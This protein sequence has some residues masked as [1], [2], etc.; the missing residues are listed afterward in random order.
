MSTVTQAGVGTAH[1]ADRD[2]PASDSDSDGADESFTIH[3]VAIGAG[4][5]TVGRSGITKQ[6][7]ADE[8]E[9]AADTLEGKPLVR[10]HENTTDG[11]IGTVVRAFYRAGVGVLYQAEIAPHYEDI[12]QDIEAGI[13][14]V[15]ARAYHASTETLEADDETGALVV[16][17]IV[18]DNLAVVSQGAAPS[19]TVEPG[20]ATALAAG[21]SGNTVAVMSQGSERLSAAE[22][23]ATFEELDAH[24]YDT[25]DYVRGDSSGGT[26][27]GRVEGMKAE[28]CYSD[29]IDG[30]QEICAGDDEPVYL[31][32][33]VDDVTGESQDT[34]V[35]HLESSIEGWSGPSGEE[36]A[37][38]ADD[39]D[40]VYEEFQSV[41]NMSASELERWADHPCATE[42]SVDTDA[43]IDRNMR[44]LDTNKDDWDS[45][46]I[47]DAQ[48]TIS[49][50]NRMSSDDNRPE[51]P[52]DGPH[53]CPSKWAISLLNWAHNPFDSMPEVPDEMAESESAEENAMHGDASQSGGRS[54]TSDM[55]R[56]DTGDVPEWSEGDLV[57]WQVE[58]DLFGT[59]VHVD[60]ETHVAMVEI[61]GMSDSNDNVGG[62]M[63]STGFTITA[64]FSDI[65]PMNAPTAQSDMS[66]HDNE[67]DEM[68][69]DSTPDRSDSTSG[70]SDPCD[71]QSDS[72]PDQ[73]DSGDGRSDQDDAVLQSASMHTPEWSGLDDSREW[74]RPS[75]SDFDTDDLS[76]IDDH[77]F[78]SRTGFPPDAYGDLALP[79]VWP[80]GDLSA[81]ALDSVHRMATQT[82]GVPDDTTESIKTRAA[83]LAEEHFDMSLGADTDDEEASATPVA[84]L[85]SDSNG[86]TPQSTQSEHNPNSTMTHIETYDV[87]DADF[88]EE[89]YV[90]VD[91]DELDT[92]VEQ[93]S[94][95]DELGDRIDSVDE[96]LD[97][98]A[99]H[100]ELMSEVDDDRL[101]ELRAYDDAVV[102]P[103]SEHEELTDLVDE[104]AGIYAEALG[105][106]SPFDADELADR[107][108]PSELADRVDEHDEASLDA[109]IDADDD[110]DPDG[111]SVDSDE[112]SGSDSTDGD[113]E[114][115]D[116]DEDELRSEIAED[117]ESGGYRR[118]AEKVRD[119]AFDIEALVEGQI[120]F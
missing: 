112:L 82:E 63:E 64:G 16:E 109:E 104:V 81:D 5:V 47:A 85:Q 106:H 51:S 103:E 15:S 58:P 30:D 44:L 94:T 65:T 40:A 79:A 71:D 13:L 105:E 34:M 41:T 54:D 29:A 35:A 46:D 108:T 42:A 53:G 98:L 4:D 23:S 43:V 86:H 24:A 37:S 101:D 107:F 57:R 38:N 9:R 2:D 114:S 100:R 95:A 61:M 90:A 22:L 21:P 67:D 78:A 73:S 96:T 50:V 36:N 52:R 91:R 18:F 59:I 62:S 28:G 25:G 11:T 115:A 92:L 110:V 80:N 117:L 102:L 88:D 12:A 74:S 69:A 8:L 97:E 116:I 89:N 55:P 17:D 75:M 33:I 66:D 6:W 68:S 19:N 120:E 99:E 93:A 77:F 31:I 3:G 83:T 27:H 119:G 39:L 7:P 111:G 10:D 84:T 26:W 60:D 48:R 72:T 14:D 118:Q 32:A 87:S 45:D 56:S 20:E 113:S 70:G 49:F 1:L 76:T